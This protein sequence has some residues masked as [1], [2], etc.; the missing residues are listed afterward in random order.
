MTEPLHT[1]SALSG[2]RACRDP[3]TEMLGLVSKARDQSGVVP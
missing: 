1:S 2:G 3:A